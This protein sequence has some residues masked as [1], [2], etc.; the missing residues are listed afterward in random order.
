MTHE[1]HIPAGT[2]P[3]G[4]DP[5]L[6][7]PQTAGWRFCGLRIV[8]LAPGQSR[9][10]TTGE[11]EHAVLPL[12]GGCVVETEGHRFDLAGRATVFSRPTD[13]AYLPRDAEARITSPGGA[14]LALPFAHASR[15]LQPAYLPAEAVPVEIR[16]AGH[17]TRQVN[18]FLHPDAFE[19]DRLTCIEVLTP[20][21][22]TSSYP[23]HKHDA[24][25]P[26][27]RGQAILEEIYYFEIR[28]AGGTGIHRT[29]TRDGEI[30]ATVTI[31]D[32]DAFLIPRGFHGPCVALP[33]YDL[34]YLNVLAGPA[35]ER[36]LAF[37]DDEPHA[38]IR[39]SWE[40]VAPD[41][42]LPFDDRRPTP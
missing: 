10:L 19:T 16:G 38:W 13:F 15:R 31:R 2:A 23:P 18:N 39:A 3:D 35:E 7:T 22:N 17:A 4:A 29:Y 42:R 30:D 21:G 11:D 41:P 26:A 33:G 28:G 12:A 14:R 34:Y 36:S 9:E 40:G 24:D 27:G 5:L 8:E 6:I 37:L 32:G 25:E 1:L 20:E